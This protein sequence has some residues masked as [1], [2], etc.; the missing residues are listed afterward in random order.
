MD[1]KQFRTF[2]QSIPGE[3][4][5]RAGLRE[6]P[7][8]MAAAW[9]FWLSGYREDP[10]SVLKCFEDGAEQYDELVFQGDVPFFSVCEHHAAPFFGLVHL[11]YV[12]DKRIVGLSKLARVVEIYAR[13]L[14][15]QERLVGQIADALM[16]HV[17]PKG[18]GVTI[19][20]RHLCL[21]SR[22]I[23]KLGTVTTTTALRGV[24]KTNEQT[25]AEYMMLVNRAGKP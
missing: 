2:L 24:I 5:D 16:V 8:R 22:G 21:E 3:N 20:A 17:G 10:A 23:Q 1:E 15:V 18:V 9:Q 13:R 12:P 25:R 14:Q 11:G 19:Q 6:T 7:R 4:P